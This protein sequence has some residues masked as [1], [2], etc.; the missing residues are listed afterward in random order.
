[1]IAHNIEKIP[2]GMV[3]AKLNKND[4]YILANLDCLTNSDQQRLKKM[5]KGVY[6]SR[7]K[8]KA[9]FCFNGEKFFIGV[10]DTKQQAQDAYNLTAVEMEVITDERIRDTDTYNDSPF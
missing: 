1:M 2:D 4:G 7:G 3:V 9:E 10:F 5:N 6:R 8:W